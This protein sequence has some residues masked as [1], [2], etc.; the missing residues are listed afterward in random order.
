MKE[1]FAAKVEELCASCQIARMV[2]GRASGVMSTGVANGDE[3]IKAT[4]KTGKKFKNRGGQTGKN[5]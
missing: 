1:S 4:L 5:A 2:A 3:A